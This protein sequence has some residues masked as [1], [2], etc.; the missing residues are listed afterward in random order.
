MKNE[1]VILTTENFD[2]YYEEIKTLFNS[3]GKNLGVN[4]SS[5]NSFTPAG[6]GRYIKYIIE[7]NDRPIFFLY[8]CT[9]DKGKE[10][11][12][13]YPLKDYLNKE[14]DR[15]EKNTPQYFWRTGNMR[16]YDNGVHDHLDSRYFEADDAKYLRFEIWPQDLSRQC[17]N[18]FKRLFDHF[19]NQAQNRGD[20]HYFDL[21]TKEFLKDFC[22]AA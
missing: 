17:L 3:S 7:K 10:Y 22:V 21:L 12:R 1:T 5:S 18:M 11:L 16:F 20:K 9:N 4:W 13:L 6:N 14:W 2:H 15:M 19:T 8:L